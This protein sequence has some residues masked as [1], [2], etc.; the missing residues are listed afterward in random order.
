MAKKTIE[1]HYV[2]S[3]HWDREWYLPFQGFRYRL[4]KL[5][6]QLIDLLETNADYKYFVFDGQSVALDDYLEVRPENRERLG[7]LIREGRILVG[8]WYTMPDERILGGESLIRNLMRGF[9]G[10]RSWG[11]EPM[12]YGYVC[13]IFGHIAQ[14]PQIF[15][16]M[17]IGYALLGRGTN[18]HTHPA[19]FVWRAPD[20]SEVVTFKEQDAAGYGAGRHIW[21]AAG[22]ATGEGFDRKAVLEAA[23]ALR[24]KEA[25][26]SD[27]PV[28]LWLDGLDHQRPG[29]RIPDALEAIRKDMPD[30]EV[31]FST[32]PIFAEAVEK[33]R[34]KLPV[35]EGELIDVAKAEGGYNYLI[36]HCLSSY[37][38][39]KQANDRCQTALEKWAEPLMA[40]AGVTAEAPA[41]RGFLD[42][43]WRF[44]IQNHPHDSICGCSIDQV[45]KDTEYR[46]DQCRLIADEVARDCMEALAPRADESPS[47]QGAPPKPLTLSVFSPSPV[48]AKRVVTVEFDYPREYT[49]RGLR[50]FSDDLI[51]VFDLLDSEGRRLDYQLHGYLAGD[52]CVALPAWGREVSRTVKVRASFEAAFDGICAKNFRVVPRAS[53]YRDLGT[54]LTGPR[55]MENEHLRVSANADG[56]I[57]L[58]SKADGREWKELCVFEDTG[59]MGDGWYHI[60][61]INN[62]TFLSTGFPTGVSVKEDGTFVTTLRIEKTMML[63]SGLDWATMRRKDERAAVRLAFDVTLRKG[64]PWVECAAVLDNTVTDHRLRVLLTTGV[65]GDEYFANQPFTFVTRRR[66]IDVRTRDWKECDEEEK[67]FHGIAG[68]ADERGGLAFVGGP[69]LHEVAMKADAEGTLAVTLMRGFKR[70][71]LPPYG[72]RGQLLGRI[73][74][75]W[76]IVPFAGA[77]DL[78]SLQNMQDAFHAGV[79]SVATRGADH[80]GGAFVAFERGAAVL[81]A[82]KPAEDGD[83]V[84]LRVYNPTGQAVG[85]T[86]RFGERTKSSVEVNSAEEPLEGAK[87]A[88]GGKTLGIDL[89]PHRIRTFRLTF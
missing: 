59:E 29:P 68:V 81:S 84:I 18:E 22:G 19:H 8:P 4:V 63:P 38:P 71:V 78:A 58:A 57:D 56:T 41:A 48:A 30:A 44:L 80:E 73:D 1:I 49:K 26:R 52:D 14:M 72:G 42:V 24:E 85:E 60:R 16:G 75:Q 31:V 62:Q 47:G 77:G 33:H 82:L 12:R 87:K 66:G 11:V 3:T 39:M 6:D 83:G 76:R 13:D 88:R 69:G 74:W 46:Y 45:H 25:T 35:I 36:S 55:T 20:G 79:R 61:P 21:Q 64:G 53:A 40:W 15:A 43:A 32:L 67:N 50:G 54:Q 51:P 2:A 28:Q 70:A 86:A 17:G 27:V 34:A 65:A 23:R 7:S 89:A 5:V 10:A 9:A 37:Y